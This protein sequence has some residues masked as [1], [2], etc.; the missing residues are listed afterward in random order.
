MVYD[1][2]VST[3]TPVKIWK[4]AS[5]FETK[6]LSLPFILRRPHLILAESLQPIFQVEPFAQQLCPPCLKSLE[7]FGIGFVDWRFIRG[8]IC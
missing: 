2:A 6:L 1:S 7:D 3:F 5:S 4:H 8:G